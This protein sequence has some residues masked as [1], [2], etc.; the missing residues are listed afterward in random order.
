MKMRI[1]RPINTRHLTATIAP[2]S[3]ALLSSCMFAPM[4]RVLSNGTAVHVGYDGFN[5]ALAEVGIGG[6]KFGDIGFGSCGS[7]KV[8]VISSYSLAVNVQPG[9]PRVVALEGSIWRS[10]AIGLGLNATYYTDFTSGSLQFRPEFGVEFP[11]GPVWLRGTAGY[12]L[13]LTNP[14]LAGVNQV[15]YAVR[16]TIPFDKPRGE[17]YPY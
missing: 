7:L 12:N 17:R 6:F 4:D 15:Q 1:K 9:E 2:L 3:L 10:G 13:P 5:P 11:L 16:L 8:P 14:F